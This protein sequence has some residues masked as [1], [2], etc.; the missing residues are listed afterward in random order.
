MLCHPQ[1]IVSTSEPKMD[2]QTPAIMSPN[3]KD[4]MK[5]LT[6]EKLPAT[7][8]C[9]HS[10]Y[11]HMILWYGGLH[12]RMVK[13]YSEHIPVRGDHKFNAR[14]MDRYQATDDKE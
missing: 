2:V 14:V 10:I 1:H 3:K 5:V 4:R 7:T 8:H 11:Q 6:F 13:F 12:G 9:L